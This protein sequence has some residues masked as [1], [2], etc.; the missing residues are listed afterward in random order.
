MNLKILRYENT[1][2]HNDETPIIIF[3]LGEKQR[4]LSLLLDK[5]A[6]ELVFP[7]IYAGKARNFTVHL[8]YSDVSNSEV[9]RFDCRAASFDHL[10]YAAYTKRTKLL[11]YQVL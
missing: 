11:R 6:E 4:P 1:L 5:S 3:A 7:T 2:L 9:R 8:T 10:L